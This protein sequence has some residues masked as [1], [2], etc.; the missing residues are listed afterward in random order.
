MP[1]ELAAAVVALL[2]AACQLAVVELR[3]RAAR[4]ELHAQVA[5]VKRRVGADRRHHDLG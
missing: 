1:T 2:V 5:D 3:A 4:R